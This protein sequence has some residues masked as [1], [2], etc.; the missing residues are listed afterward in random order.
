MSIA[1]ALRLSQKDI[2]PLT[3]LKILLVVY[4]ILSSMFD[5][6]KRLTFIDN[7]PTKIIMLLMILV[8]MYY[9]LHLGILL[10]IAFLIIS[11]QLNIPTMSKID[12]R[13]LELFLSSIPAELSLENTSDMVSD[14]AV[15]DNTKKNELSEDILNYTVDTK[16]KPYEVFVKLMTTKEDL[17]NAANSAFLDSELTQ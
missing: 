17:D 5:F 13:K 12:E 4:I 8:V 2:T 7:K 1:N 3:L 14:V 6:N 10:V 15:C 11:I 16:V 9:E